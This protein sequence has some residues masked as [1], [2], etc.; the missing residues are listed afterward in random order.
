MTNEDVR[1]LLEGML[2]CG[3][4][5]GILSAVLVGLALLGATM[6]FVMTLGFD[7]Y[8]PFLEVHRSNMSKRQPDGTILRSPEGKVLKPDG[9]S[10]AELS[11]ILMTYWIRLDGLN[12]A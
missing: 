10:P 9:Y 7:P 12:G 4:A 1:I 2:W 6:S 3:V 8:L 11:L 5:L